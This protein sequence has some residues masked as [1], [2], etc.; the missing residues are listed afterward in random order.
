MR[1]LLRR[2]GQRA[3]LALDFRAEILVPRLFPGENVKGGFMA[4]AKQAEDAKLVTA[5]ETLSADGAEIVKGRNRGENKRSRPRLEPR[6]LGLVRGSGQ[7][8]PKG[9]RPSEDARQKLVMFLACD[10]QLATGQTLAVGRSDKSGFG[11]LV[12]SV[13]QW[14]GISDDPTEAAAYA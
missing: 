9:G 2:L 10:W 5:L 7:R 1:R 12:H 6:V 4:W 8:K 3:S 11:D 14:L 13:F